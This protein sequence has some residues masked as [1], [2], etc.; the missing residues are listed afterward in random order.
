MQ[1]FAWLMLLAA[2]GSPA[3]APVTV[4]PAS[5]A[6][7][8]QSA[9]AAPIVDLGSDRSADDQ[10]LDAGRKPNEM[11]AFFGIRPGMHVAEIVAAGGYTT[12][13]LARAVGPKGEVYGQNPKFI[14]EKF[15]ESPWSLRLGK[16]VM[17]NVRRVDRELDDPLPPE[18]RNLD[19]VIDVLFYH[20]TVW[21]K[22]DREKMNH[23][24][25][26][27]LRSGGVYGI[28]DHAAKAG[29]GLTEVETLHRIEEK[30][31]VEEVTRA[32]FVLA[33][34]SDALRNPADTK[35]WS[36]SPRAAGAKRGTSDRFMLKFVKK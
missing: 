26:A 10:A 35:D 28:I 19:A 36:T 1:R 9:A 30:V 7:L 12:E 32:G 3:P 6:A 18:A 16:P 23:A 8:A 5:S 4:T 24:I 21:M 2:C 31:V 29:A 33:E 25:F 11:L 34:Q 22:T 27:A 17:A 20:D 14:L 13:L 15:A